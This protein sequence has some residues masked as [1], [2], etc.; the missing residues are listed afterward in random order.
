[1]RKGAAETTGMVS[2]VPQ[3]VL[4]ALLRM[5]LISKPLSDFRWRFLYLLSLEL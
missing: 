4:P 2:I 1:M 5:S 3:F